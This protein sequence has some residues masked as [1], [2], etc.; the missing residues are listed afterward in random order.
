MV[1]HY[2]GMVSWGRHP[3][4]CERLGKRSTTTLNE[5]AVTCKVCNRILDD[6]N[7]PWERFADEDSDSDTRPKD[8]DA[9]QGSTRE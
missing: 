6:V 8:G 3:S 1:V 4:F 9:K 7:S 2:Q 5:D